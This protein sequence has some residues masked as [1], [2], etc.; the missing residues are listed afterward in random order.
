MRP[1]FT[2]APITDAGRVVYQGESGNVTFLIQGRQGGNDVHYLH[3]E[4]TERRRTRQ[5]KLDKVEM[6]ILHQRGA[7]IL[8]PRSLCDAIIDTY[9]K[10]VHPMLPVINRARFMRQYRN[11]KN[12]PSL[13]LLHA[14]LLAGS[15]FCDTDLAS[16]NGSV[17]PDA[18]ILYKR[19]KALY[20]AN[21]EDDRVAIIQ[22]VLLMG[23]Y[24]EDPKDV[25][26]NAF[27]WSRVAGIIAQGCGMH[28]T[29][30]QS[31]LSKSDKRLWKRIW[32]TLFTVD[33]SIAV[34]FG[35]PTYIDLQNCDVEMVTE[36]DF[37]ED[38]AD[39][40]DRSNGLAS[41][42]VH[43]QF[44]LQYVKL[45][46]IMGHIL[47][48]HYPAGP[49][50]QQRPAVHSTAA[51]NDISLADW[52][53]NCP[54]IVYWEAPR[55]HFWSAILH[56][57]YY[58]TLCL[59]H[60]VPVPRGDS[61]HSRRVSSQA[62]AM[63]TSI[64]ESLAVSGQ[65]RYCPPSIVYSL[66]SALI[67]HVN[68]IHTSVS[69]IRQ[70]VTDKLRS[71]MSALKA[72]SHVWLTG[73]M[74]YTLFEP[75]IRNNLPEDGVQTFGAKEPEKHHNLSRPEQ[76]GKGQD[77]SKDEERLCPNLV[78][79]SPSQLASYGWS[80]PHI[81][82]AIMKQ[83]GGLREEHNTISQ[84]AP[85]SVGQ[86]VHGQGPHT[87][88]LPDFDVEMPDG[89]SLDGCAVTQGQPAPITLNMNDC[90][91]TTTDIQSERMGVYF[92][93]TENN[94]YVP[95]AI[96]TDSCPIT[97]NLIDCRP[98]TKAFSRKR[99]IFG[100][101]SFSNYWAKGFYS[102]EGGDMVEKIIDIVRLEVEDCDNLQGFQMTQS[103]A[104]GTGGGMASRLLGRLAEE[105]P[106]ASRATYAIMP[107]YSSPDGCMIRPYNTTLTLHYL[108]ELTDLATLFSYRAMDDKIINQLKMDHSFVRYSRIV[109]DTILGATTSLRFPSH[110]DVDLMQLIE[111]MVPTPRMHFL[112]S[113]MIPVYGSQGHTNMAD[114]SMAQVA[115]ELSRNRVWTMVGIHSHDTGR[116]LAYNAAF[117]GN[118]GFHDTLT[119]FTRDVRDKS[120]PAFMEWMPANP[121]FY[122]CTVPTAG[123]EISV[124]STGNFTSVVN[125]LRMTMEHFESL[126]RRR[127]FLR[128]Y[129]EHGMEEMEFMEAALNM[130][131]LISE[132]DKA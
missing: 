8:P 118:Y 82:S 3:P 55:H 13:L 110:R 2:R 30:D 121:H 124:T 25:T 79:P 42:S 37:V 92:K 56:C 98:I 65:L 129:T 111:H 67:T 26:K 78:F 74:A 75:I 106:E 61:A 72:V 20:D 11:P 89:P 88:S 87:T 16:T 4:N 12:Q 99:Q 48:Q 38:N 83:N 71:C 126:F 40:V 24:W 63:I 59:L 103:I 70:D 73:K 102:A 131:D 112:T 116:C 31:Y 54:Q 80:Q 6:N 10:C 77:L 68:E 104:S 21:Y 7:F 41:D 85:Y 127:S 60:R 64:I 36:D 93:K 14:V 45:C 91:T 66:F 5:F 29:V 49:K 57:N 44:F 51:R 109:A 119:Q 132:Y 125:E 120:N 18:Q 113:A 35:W 1:K 69:T 123:Y 76:Q 52:L 43:V 94:L 107:T 122:A 50:E 128:F 15:R 96:L 100:Q 101:H 53:R 33:R 108:T 86:G 9:F 32:W 97:A 39:G 27:Y 22:S 47:D 81:Q 114:L 90:L 58:T 19:A 62:A 115:Q 28:R 105:Y 130:N 46:V 34:A 117:R 17:V 23:L 84:M 95:R